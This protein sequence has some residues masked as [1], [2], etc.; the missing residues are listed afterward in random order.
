MKNLATLLKAIFRPDTMPEIEVMN[1]VARKVD[2]DT[3]RRK[4]RLA[5]G[6]VDPAGDLARV[7]VEKMK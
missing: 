5:A 6:G 1:F 3:E 7:I 4:K 2:E